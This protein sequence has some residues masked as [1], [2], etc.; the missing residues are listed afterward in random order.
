VFIAG[1]VLELCSTP[2]FFMYTDLAPKKKGGKEKGTRE[3]DRAVAGEEKGGDDAS[4]DQSCN[5]TND[6]VTKSK[7]ATSCFGLFS[8]KSIPKMLFAQGVM[9]SLGSGMHGCSVGVLIILCSMMRSERL[10]VAGVEHRHAFD[11]MAC[12]SDVTSLTITNVTSCH[13]IAGLPSSFLCSSK[14]ICTLLVFRWMYCTRG[15]YCTR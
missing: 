3:D 8:Y 15:C 7:R 12:L 13:C 10:P 1:L 6:A 9:I 2:F 11:L 4:L 14:T 5:T